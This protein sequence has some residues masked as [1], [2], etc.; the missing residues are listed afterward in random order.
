MP[1]LFGILGRSR[2]Y[3]ALRKAAP[4]VREIDP[5]IV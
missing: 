4:Y 3:P 5:F 2:V 1:A